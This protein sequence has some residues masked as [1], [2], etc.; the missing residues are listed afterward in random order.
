MKIEE[1][2]KKIDQTDSEILSLMSRRMLLSIRAGRLKKRI[3]D[4]KREEEILTN[5]RARQDRLLFPSFSEELYSKIFTESKKLQRKNF[6]LAGFQGERGAFGESACEAFDDSYIPV[7]CLEFSD[8]FEGVSNG[9]LDFGVV[10]IENSSEGAISSVSHLVTEKN[11]NIIGEVVL[12]VHHSLLGLSN[13]SL[14]G[15]KVVYSHPQALAQCRNFIIDNKLEPRPYYD[16]AGAAAMIAKEKPTAAAAI[17]GR[18]CSDLYGLK[19]LEENIEDSKSNFT[20]FLVISGGKFLGKGNKCSITFSTKD[21]AGALFSVLGFFKEAGINLTMIE[22]IPT[23]DSTGRAKFLIDFIGGYRN[24]K[25]I[26]TL[27][28]IKAQTTEFK[29]LGCYRSWSK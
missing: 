21:K 23:R 8:V 7:P 25:T 9:E 20:R 4:E 26:E 6:K 14:E 5:L 16:T 3:R 15:V 18:N 27:E 22:S 29:L 19:V 13:E 24:K 12:P 28:K 1:L 2:R 17:A 10:P 11:V